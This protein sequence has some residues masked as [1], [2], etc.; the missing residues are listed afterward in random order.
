MNP[1]SS[2]EA[3]R[4][5][6]RQ[7]FEAQYEAILGYALRR[8]PPDD[9]ADI[10]AE[11]FLVAWRRLSAVPTDDRARLWL[12]GTARRVVAN[13]NRSQRRRERLRAHLRLEARTNEPA[14]EEPDHVAAAF[15]RLAPE[16]RELL[17]LAA[18][19]GLS[20]AEIGTLMGCSTNAARIR[21]HR[22]RR[23]LARRLDEESAGLAE[24]S[25]RSAT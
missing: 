10:V 20:A 23:K 16:E 8:V 5:R 4:E 7:L 9:A 3:R 25:L 19:E 12:Y 13:R 15:Q 1:L 6:F 11:T 22:A 17:A 14:A 2:D 18:W 24:R 21:L